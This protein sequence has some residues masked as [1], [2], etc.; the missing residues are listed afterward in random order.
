VFDRTE[1]GDCGNAHLLTC[2]DTQTTLANYEESKL[3]LML[4]LRLLSG[5]NRREFSSKTLND[6]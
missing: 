6:Q 2:G 4:R 1:K 5:R 3:A